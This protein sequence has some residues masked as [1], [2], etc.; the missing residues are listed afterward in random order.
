MIELLG[1]KLR[2][3]DSPTSLDAVEFLATITS[4]LAQYSISV[5]PVSAYYHDLLFVPA[6]RAREVMQL[7]H[8]F[9]I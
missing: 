6:A 9:S 7:L 8:E 3:G 1:Y 5:N 2:I 4:K